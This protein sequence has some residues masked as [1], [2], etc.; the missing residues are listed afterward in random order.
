MESAAA[1][2]A[3][4]CSSPPS[5]STTGAGPAPVLMLSRTLKWLGAL[6]GQL[7]GEEGR[8][9]LPAAMELAAAGNSWRQLEQTVD[10][11]MATAVLE[12]VRR[13]CNPHQQVN[14]R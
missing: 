10:A 12:V 7:G 6:C 2:A 8:V 11:T 5:T 4:T 14:A 1:T 3:R 13:T 9:R